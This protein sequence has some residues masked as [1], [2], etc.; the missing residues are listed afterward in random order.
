M[1][2]LMKVTKPGSFKKKVREKEREK[3]SRVIKNLLTR[4]DTFDIITPP[5]NPLEAGRRDL[6]QRGRPSTTM[7]SCN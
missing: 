5:R 4:H 7:V 3:K 6:T 2:S 1:V